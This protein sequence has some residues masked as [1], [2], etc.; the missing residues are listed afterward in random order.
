M[1]YMFTN[2]YELTDL[3]IDNFDFSN[4]VNMQYMFLGCHNLKNIDLKNMIIQ[5]NSN[6]TQLIGNN[7]KNLV[8]CLDD[9]SLINQIISLY[10]WSYVNCDGNWGEKIDKISPS[11]NNKC[12]NNVLLMNV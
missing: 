7:I 4:V 6:I 5:D 2:C 1:T 9:I 8:I 10:D 12:I 3:K 11:D